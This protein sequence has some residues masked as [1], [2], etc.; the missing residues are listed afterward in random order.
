MQLTHCVKNIDLILFHADLSTWTPLQGDHGFA[1]KHTSAQFIG[2]WAGA[3]PHYYTSNQCNTIHFMLG[4]FVL[5]HTSLGILTRS[6]LK[7]RRPLGKKGTC[8]GGWSSESLTSIFESTGSPPSTPRQRCPPTL[9]GWH[10]WWLC[11]GRCWP[12]RLEKKPESDPHT[13]SPF[14][15]WPSHGHRT[16]RHKYASHMITKLSRVLFPLWGWVRQHK[17]KYKETHPSHPHIRNIREF[18]S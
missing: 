16:H 11:V 6:S 13:S 5:H 1:T 7:D 18:S 4:R 15:P 17:H 8:V 14:Y 3:H 2:C 10:R 9:D 12:S